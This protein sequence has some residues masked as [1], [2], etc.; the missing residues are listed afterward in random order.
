VIYALAAAL[1]VAGALAFSVANAPWRRSLPDLVW[2]EPH[3]GGSVESSAARNFASPRRA[4]AALARVEAKAWLSS[5]WFAGVI[6]FCALQVIVFGF[7]WATD[8]STWPLFVVLYPIMAHPA[9]GMAVVGAHLA[10]T[11]SRRDR[12]E[13]IFAACPADEATRTGGHALSGWVVSLAL[14]VFVVV[15]TATVSVKAPHLYG[16]R[17]LLVGDALA[18]VV[19]GWC[20]VTLGVA[21]ARWASWP[22]VP[23]VCVAA[24]VPAIAAVG[25]IGEPHWSNVRQLS[26]WP[27]YPSHDLVFTDRHVWSHLAWLVALGLLMV[28][29]ALLHARRD[30]VM[31]VVVGIAVI[32]VV[33]AALVTARPISHASA[34]RLASMVADPAAHQT[35]ET[36]GDVS[37]CVFRGSER[38]ARQLS[39]E[40][41]PV[42]RALRDVG[43]STRVALRQHLDNRVDVLGPEVADALGGRPIGRPGIALGHEVN[44]ASMVRARLVVA[45]HALGLPTDARHQLPYVAAGQ[46]RGVAALWLAAQ[47]LPRKEQVDVA[48]FHLSWDKEHS[49]ARDL[50]AFDLGDA[51]PKTCDG[52]L[53]ALVW[54]EIDL[55]A[56]RLLIAKPVADVRAALGAA[57]ARLRDP[58]MTTNDLLATVGLGPLPAPPR[59]T[60][61]P[62]SC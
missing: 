34:A 6:A 10:V 50:T 47:G 58:A 29:I 35:C 32:G 24:L 52:M 1:V 59:I 39:A 60:P 43:L 15:M 28:V 14:A 33:A 31:R 51:W 49:G 45:S 13:E 19:L 8:N 53:P 26:T 11:R 56:A 36:T 17:G 12:S 9:T 25:N 18:A 4:A 2:A 46:A 37:A 61:E 16:W 57:G 5:A 41:R 62:F 40:L 54:S 22:L 30:R 38:Y 3:R 44:R 21:L 42:D 20:G 48:T 23:I 27:R 55:L 7:V